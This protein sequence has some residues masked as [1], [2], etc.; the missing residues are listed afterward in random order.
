MQAAAVGVEEGHNLD[1]R[2]LCVEGLGVFEIVIPD[3][4]TNVAKKFHNAMFGRFVAGVVIKAGFMGGLCTNSD[5]CRG[6]VGNV[7][8]V[9]GEADETYKC[10][11]AMFCFVLGG[12]REDSRERMDAFQLIIG[13][14]HEKRKNTLSDGKQVVIGWFPFKRGKSVLFFFEEAGDGVRRH[15]EMTLED[16]LLRSSFLD[17]RVGAVENSDDDDQSNCVGKGELRVLGAFGD[18]SESVGSRDCDCS[19]VGLVGIKF[20]LD[21][22][23]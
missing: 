3:L 13:N 20:E 10:G 21:F 1:G 17:S 16:K 14:D 12:F 22:Y 11:V 15:V 9:E 4:I 18:S 8:I 5:D 6:V 7:F 19:S 2:D 23:C